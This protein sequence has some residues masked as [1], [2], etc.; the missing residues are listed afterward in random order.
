MRSSKIWR[1]IWIVGIYAVLVLILLL[2]IDYKVRWESK[3]LNTYL[4]FYNCNN[5]LCAS[6]I[7]SLLA[8]DLPTLL[9]T[10]RNVFAIPPPSSK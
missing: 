7:I 9:F 4:Y 2:V 6:I 5:N 1:I 8:K 3:D 10:F